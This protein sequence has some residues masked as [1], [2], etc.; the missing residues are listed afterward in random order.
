MVNL[1][2]PFVVSL[3][4]GVVSIV[5]AIFAIWLGRSAE[6][7]SRAN[8]DQTKD[9]MRDYYDRTKEVLAEIDKRAAVTE[10]TVTESQQQLLETVTNLLKQTA[11][12]P[13][14]DPAEEAQQAFFQTMLQDPDK[15]MQMIE[16]LAAFTQQSE[17]QQSQA[18]KA[19]SRRDTPRK[20]P[21]TRGRSR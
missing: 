20:R 5:L 14:T 10:K 13:K 12:P 8:F 11:V 21:N 4:I 7:E 2:I 17:K 18:S 3:I 6:R 15:G 9:T 19:Q 16:K 1:D